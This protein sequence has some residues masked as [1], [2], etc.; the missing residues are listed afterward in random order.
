MVLHHGFGGQFW[1]VKGRPGRPGGEGARPKPKKAAPPAVTPDEEK[2][3]ACLLAEGKLSD[4]E[5]RDVRIMLE[6]ARRVGWT[7]TLQEAVQRVV[8]AHGPTHRPA[9]GV[10]HDVADIDPADLKII[11][12]IGRGS[13]AVVH[14]CV[15]QPTG[16]VFAVKILDARAAR[17]PD[18]RNR[19]VSE[20]RQFARLVHPNLVRIY[21]VGPLRDTFLIVMEYVDGGSVADVLASRGRLDPAEAVRIIRAAAVGLAFIHRAGFIH[22]DIKPKNILLTRQGVPKI[23]DMGLAMRNAD[24]DAAFE[25]VGK[26]SGTPYYM[27]PEQIRGD[28][29]TDHRTDIYSLGATLYEMVTGRPPFTT[30]DPR[31]FREVMQMH[32]TRPVPDPRHFVPNLPESLCRVLATALAKNPQDRYRKADFLVRA[33]DKTGLVGSGPPES[34]EHGR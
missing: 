23:A 7:L 28:P 17:N 14:K 10:A 21:H 18:L 15:H 32:L 9:A 3:L 33:L 13:Q 1:P 11:E 20:G 5:A 27:S 4:A 22:R 26:A 16:R 24:I 31:R 12:K 6:K 30:S 34:N 25:E 8:A 29:D 2:A 19:F